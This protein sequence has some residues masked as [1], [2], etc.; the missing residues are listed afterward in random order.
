MAVKYWDYAN[1][2]DTTGDGSAG[3]P[4]KT[5]DKASAEAGAGGEVRCAGQA[6]VDLG[7]ATWTQDSTTVTF[8]SAP[9]LSA[10]DWIRPAGVT[11]CP[12]Y[13]VASVAGTT[14][15]LSWAYRGAS[16]T[17][18]THKIPLVTLTAGLNVAANA[19]IFTFG[20]RLSDE[21]QPD[22][23]VSAF[24][25]NIGSSTP[26]IKITYGGTWYC[27]GRLFLLQ[28]AAYD[29]AVYFASPAYDA[30]CE[31]KGALD[32]SG[33]TIPS[34]F[35]VTAGNNAA[36]WKVLVEKLLSSYS[37]QVIG[38][39][40][41]E[42]VFRHLVAH[43]TVAPTGSAGAV[44]Y[45]T[46][47][48]GRL[49]IENL[50]ASYAKCVAFAWAGTC[51]IGHLWARQASQV[52]YHL[53]GSNYAEVIC[54]YFDGDDTAVT[55]AQRIRCIVGGPVTQWV[56][57]DAHCGTADK[58]AGRT[59]YGLRVDP[60]NS[61]VPMS[62]PFRFTVASGQTVT[63]SCYAY[64]SGTGGVPRVWWELCDSQGCT[65]DAQPIT[66]PNGTGW[67]NAQK[68]SVTFTGTTAQA[69]VMIAWL[70]ICDNS[71][72][73]AVCYFDD[74]ELSTGAGDRNTMGL[75]VHGTELILQQAQAAGGSGIA[76]P[77]G[78]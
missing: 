23:Y 11:D 35:Y 68:L 14:V 78:L 28:N 71:G 43:N 61:I 72:G 76:F 59:G 32:V 47:G 45:I 53:V 4:Y 3:N 56:Y 54:G 57:K 18:T 20:W 52:G 67:S 62:L 51:Y 41:S 7:T 39:V 33:S 5:L 1:G 13:R 34:A 73:D 22:G 44:A 69:G 66:L 40:R 15:T 60:A 38:V 10:G 29:Y 30:G 16:A 48:G 55:V 42:V 75:E 26:M 49:Y 21:T 46:E 63:I 6:L 31:F 77:I 2:S 8:N 50:H 9:S 70:H 27:N 58:V 25:G 37:Y 74:F 12:A 36:I 19:Q 64:Y 24:L 65:V 17:C